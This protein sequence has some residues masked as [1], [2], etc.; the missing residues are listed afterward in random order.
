MRIK[1]IKNANV[2]RLRQRVISKGLFYW[3]YVCEAIT[4]NYFYATG[5]ARKLKNLIKYSP[6]FIIGNHEL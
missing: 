4:M 6:S 3:I 2:Y 5:E 1:A